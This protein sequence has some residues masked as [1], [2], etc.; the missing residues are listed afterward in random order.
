[1]GPEDGVVLKAVALPEKAI[2][3]LRYGLFRY[4]LRIGQLLVPASSLYGI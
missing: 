2:E 3:R 4:A 1:M